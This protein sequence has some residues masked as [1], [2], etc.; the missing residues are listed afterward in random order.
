[1]D[2]EAKVA[3]EDAEKAGLATNLHQQL[4]IRR[5][6]LA[7]CSKLLAAHVRSEDLVVGR[8]HTRRDAGEMQARCRRDT[9]EIQA[10]YRR[11]AGEM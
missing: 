2:P 5:S 6:R 4:E 11:D 3:S 8:L 1:M 10:R 9:G 7:S